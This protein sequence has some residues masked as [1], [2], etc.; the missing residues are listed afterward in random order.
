MKC[1]RC[2][3]ILTDE[4]SK[5]KGAGAVCY[6]KI[7]KEPKMRARLRRYVLQTQKQIELKF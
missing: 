1:F 6:G 5:A 7:K 2:G 4:K 3:K